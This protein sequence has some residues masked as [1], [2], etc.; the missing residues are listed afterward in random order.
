MHFLA[1]NDFITKSGCK[2]L[3]VITKAGLQES[4]ASLVNS[5]RSVRAQTIQEPIVQ[6]QRGNITN[7]ISSQWIWPAYILSNLAPV[8]SILDLNKY[9]IT[10]TDIGG[11]NF[12][13]ALTRSIKIDNT[14]NP[15]LILNGGDIFNGHNHTITM[16]KSTIG[17]LFCQQLLSSSKYTIIK[18]INVICPNVIDIDY[19]NYNPSGGGLICGYSFFLVFLIVM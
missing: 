7:Y 3:E 5:I 1:L 9:H 4:P 14:Y 16:K 19:W 11:G 17:I 18:N 6:T 2:T 8:T 10:K 13:Y 15:I 12:E